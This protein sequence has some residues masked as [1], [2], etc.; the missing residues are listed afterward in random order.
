MIDVIGAPFDLCGKRLGSRLGP[1][2]IRLAGLIDALEGLD[3]SVVDCGDIAALPE[4]TE[5][6]GLRNFR[7]M[8][9]C[10][11]QLRALVLEGLNE[12][13]IPVVLGGE[14]SVA[15]GGISAALQYFEGDLG[16][17]W[18]D[19]H[20]DINTPGTSD[21]GSIHGMP[22]AALA[23]FESETSGMADA[24]WNELLTVLGPDHKLDPNAIAWFGLR[25]VDKAERERLDGLPVSMHHIDRLG[26]EETIAQIDEFFVEKGVRN[27]WISFDVDALDPA[28][29]PG[30]GTDVR[31]GLTYR[32]AHLTA[33][34]LYE[35]MSGSQCPY[36]L[37]G[38]DLVETNPLFDNRNETAK[39]S[40]EWLASLFGKTI[41]G[42]R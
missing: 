17:L 9:K 24:E 22:L 2:A 1:A 12:R 39:M 34:L 31:G 16:V 10:V 8:L 6:G 13:R 26:I 33:E 36:R 38:V 41:L 4:C 32:E 29:A 19:A 11:S 5:D 18:I 40:V 35:A 25:D 42:K 21:T 30:T 20:A 27:I 15:M 7:P 23:G 28:L 14:H 3:Q 37:A